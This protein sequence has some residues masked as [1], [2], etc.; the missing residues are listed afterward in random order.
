M[1][2]SAKPDNLPGFAVA[3]ACGGRRYFIAAGREKRQPQRTLRMQLYIRSAIVREVELELR[4]GPGSILS[5]G[6]QRCQ[7]D[8]RS[9]AKVVSAAQAIL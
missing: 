5:D 2:L 3:H 6:D 8:P 1:P 9:A 4:I 7:A